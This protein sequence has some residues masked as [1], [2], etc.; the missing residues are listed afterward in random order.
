MQ[1]RL[2]MCW[3]VVIDIDRGSRSSC[4]RYICVI[5]GLIMEIEKNF[6]HGRA[7]ALIV[8]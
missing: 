3:T 5:L 4:I 7:M 2:Q 8:N 6:V 1:Q